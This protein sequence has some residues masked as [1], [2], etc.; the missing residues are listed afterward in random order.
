M[1]WSNVAVDKYSASLPY[2]WDIL[3]IEVMGSTTTWMGMQY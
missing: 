2:S 1:T 3:E